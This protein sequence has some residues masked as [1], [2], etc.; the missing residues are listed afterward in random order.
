MKILSAAYIGSFS[1][2]NQLPALQLPE[3]A[4][5][6]RSNVGKSSLINCLVNRKKLALTSSTPG[7]TR[8]LNY[9]CINNQFYFVD[10]PGYGFAKV[11]QNERSSWKK[12]IESYL[13]QNPSL[14]GVIQ[15]IDSRHGFTQL[16]TEMLNWLSLHKIRTLVTATKADKLRSS[17]AKSII[18]KIEKQATAFDVPGIIPFSTV[19]KTGRNEIWKAIS[20]LLG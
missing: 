4:F 6:G 3:I 8:T 13:S 14:K 12:L 18:E 5:A 11:S 7:K 15:I 10:L 1:K 9:Y 2:L 20:E 16:D 17:K 19:T